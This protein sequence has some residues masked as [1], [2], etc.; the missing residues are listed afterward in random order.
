MPR[1]IWS[2]L[3]GSTPRR[4]ASS[5]V[6]S[7]FGGGQASSPGRWPRPAVCSWSRSNRLVA[8]VYFL[9]CFAMCGSLVSGTGGRCSRCGVR[10]ARSSRSACRPDAV[11]RVRRRRCPS[12]GRCRR[13][14]S[15]A[16]SR[17]LALRSGSLILAISATCASVTS[18]R[19]RRPGVWRALVEAGGLAQQHRRRRR[20][21]DER[22]RAVLE[23]RDL[24][25]H[26][27]APLGLG[28]GVVLL[29]EVHD[30]HAVRAERGAD[31]GRGRGLR[32]RG[33][34]S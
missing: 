26:D 29:A 17:S 19:P 13:P 3:R 12:S 2:A 22:E 1:T 24:D 9:P 14:A 6:S 34:G 4:T 16:A 11:S 31:G 7:N 33:S 8:S 30:R 23:D 20:L 25:G 15:L 32:R 10:R 5:T 21:E 28:L 27:R 18:R